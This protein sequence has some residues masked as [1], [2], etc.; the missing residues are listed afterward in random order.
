M[1]FENPRACGIAPPQQMLDIAKSSNNAINLF[2]I[3]RQRAFSAGR[4]LESSFSSCWRL[5]RQP[6]TRGT[7]VFPLPNSTCDSQFASREHAPTLLVYPNH[8]RFFQLGMLP[9]KFAGDGTQRHSF[10]L[11]EIR[12]PSVA[13]RGKESCRRQNA[14]LLRHGRIRGM[15]RTSLKLVRLRLIVH[16]TRAKSILPECRGGRE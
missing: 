14:F 5:N 16:D 7:V 8:A 11:G 3:P 15:P 4:P 12:W 2:I 10:R 1:H 6:G 13:L 9:L